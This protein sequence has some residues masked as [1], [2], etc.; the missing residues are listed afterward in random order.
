MAGELTPRDAT[1]LD[2]AAKGYSGEMMAL[3]T[4]L[5]AAACLSRVKAIL[6]ERNPLSVLEERQMLLLDLKHIKAQLLNQAKQDE[7]IDDKAAKAL[8]TTITTL[9][10]ILERQGKISDAEIESAT[11]AQAGLMLQFI[12]AGFERASALLAEKYPD[13]DLLELEAT[14]NNALREVVTDDADA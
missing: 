14:F 2:L 5:P 9:D 12:S 13:V 4:G 1:L 11:R 7:Y 8:T 3:E 10:S 6:S